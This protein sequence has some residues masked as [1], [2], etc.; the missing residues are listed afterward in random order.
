[1][2]TDR[3]ADS[4]FLGLPALGEFPD[5]HSPDFVSTMKKTVAFID[6]DITLTRASIKNKVTT[7]VLDL[8]ELEIFTDVS[9]S[10][11]YAL[12]D[13]PTLRRRLR[14]IKP[15]YLTARAWGV[16]K[17]VDRTLTNLDVYDA[18]ERRLAEFSEASEQAKKLLRTRGD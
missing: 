18:L 11:A 8:R 3:L 7:I 6:K 15:D 2:K 5:P 13:T 1:M 14:A 16:K 10:D 12:T 17:V 9:F 4:D